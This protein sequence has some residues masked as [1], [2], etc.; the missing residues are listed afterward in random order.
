MTAV[1]EKSVKIREIEG[2]RVGG[3]QGTDDMVAEPNHFKGP[4][5]IKMV[6][7]SQ[8]SGF[9]LKINSYAY[10]RPWDGKPKSQTAM[11]YG[12]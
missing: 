2:K 1:G 6:K 10:A 12:H 11:G 5:M 4:E 8:Y 7:P 3:S 9:V